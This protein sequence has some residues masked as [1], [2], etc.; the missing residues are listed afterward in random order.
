MCAIFLALLAGRAHAKAKIVPADLQRVQA[1]IR[2]PG[3]RA[4][5]VNVWATWCEP[6]VEEMPDLLRVYRAHKAQGLRLVLVSADDE[7]TRPQAEKFLA[8]QG[9]KWTTF[10]KTGDDMAFID[11]LDR[12]WSGALPAS[13]LFDGKGQV[14]H[15]WPTPVTAADLTAKLKDVL[16]RRRR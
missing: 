10:L 12:R 7:E 13:F 9:V 5:L 14:I 3:A 2:K 6:C 8:A 4:V 16:E 1:E 11:G 15:F